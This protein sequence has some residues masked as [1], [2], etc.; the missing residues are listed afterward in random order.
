MAMEDGYFNSLISQIGFE[1]QS[2]DNCLNFSLVIGIAAGGAWAT[3]SFGEKNDPAVAFTIA[4]CAL[5]IIF[6]LFLR[7]VR[8]HRNYHRYMWLK[9]EI[10]KVSDL[11]YKKDDK[12]LNNKVWEWVKEIDVIRGKE[13][14]IIRDWTM[15]KMIRY[16]LFRNREYLILI[17]GFMLLEIVSGKEVLNLHQLLF[18]LMISFEVLACGYSYFHQVKEFKVG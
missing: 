5:V 18:F 1:K 3:F 8:A 11:Y 9:G 16:S 4:C 15:P 10:V 7:S 14:E 17:L 13:G 6:A 2:F 12:T